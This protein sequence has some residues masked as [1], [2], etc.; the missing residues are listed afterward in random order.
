MHGISTLNAKA[1]NFGLGLGLGLGLGIPLI[2]VTV[3]LIIYILYTKKS[4]LQ[5]AALP[6]SA[7]L[8][9]FEMI[10]ESET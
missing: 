6:T 8:T 9:K 4:S 2:A 10:A 3:I 5:S 7:S 1:P